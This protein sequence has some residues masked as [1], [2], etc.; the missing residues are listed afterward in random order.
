[1][2]YNDRGIDRSGDRILATLKKSEGNA[3]VRV[4][5]IAKTGSAGENVGPILRFIAVEKMRSIEGRMKGRKA[6]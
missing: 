6:E 1:M 3:L 2:G 5:S 4:K